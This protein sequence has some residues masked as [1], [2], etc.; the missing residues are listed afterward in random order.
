VF[1]AFTQ[2]ALAKRV[3]SGRTIIGIGDVGICLAG[4]DGEMIIRMDLRLKRKA[5]CNW[6]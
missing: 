3:S 4:S 5:L 2:I 1:T 6:L